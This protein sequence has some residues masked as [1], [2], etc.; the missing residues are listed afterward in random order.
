M[1]DMKRQIARDL[2][3][4]TKFKWHASR[5]MCDT[6]RAIAGKLDDYRD[7]LV[8]ELARDILKH[9]DGAA[10]EHDRPIGW[11]DRLKMLCNPRKYI[12]MRLNIMAADVARRIRL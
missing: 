1:I 12:S 9:V 3:P 5:D 11:R 10:N 4:Y 6:C 7:E 8:T 2:C